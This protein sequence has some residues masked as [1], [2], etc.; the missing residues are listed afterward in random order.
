MKYDYTV[1]YGTFK[2]NDQDITQSDDHE[3]TEMNIE[4]QQLLRS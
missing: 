1:D 2:G 4:E 3:T